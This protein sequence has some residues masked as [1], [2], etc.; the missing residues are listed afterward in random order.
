MET[1]QFC[2]ENQIILYSFLPNCTHIMQM[3]D[4][5]VFKSLK[6][7]YKKTVKEWQ[8]Q[9]ENLD[10]SL[11]K[12]TFC[13]LIAHVLQ[14]KNLDKCIRNGFR[15]TGIFP[16]DPDAVDY[17]KCV[18]NNIE[19]LNASL[20]PEKPSIDDIKTT[21]NVIKY[22]RNSLICH[23]INVDLLLEVLEKDKDYSAPNS[24][25]SSEVV[26]VS[27]AD[28]CSKLMDDGN[29][30]H[31]EFLFVS[32]ENIDPDL[33]YDCEMSS[34]N[35]PMN[36]SSN[37]S[38]STYSTN[39]SVRAE[40]NMYIVNITTNSIVE[41][42]SETSNDSTNDSDGAQSN[43]V[44]ATPSSV[45][46]DVCES[47]SCSDLT[48]DSDRTESN[49]DIV[50]VTTNS[51]P[52]ILVA[53][54][55]PK[56]PTPSVDNPIGQSFKKHLFY[57]KPICSGKKRKE[58]VKTPMAISAPEWREMKQRIEDEKR[59]KAEAIQRRKRD[60]IEKA[61]QKATA[62]EERKKERIE[63]AKAKAELTLNRLKH[64]MDNLKQKKTD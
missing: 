15:S 47:S 31:I 33:G 58:K 57:P 43:I 25:V 56:F 44:D 30:D 61:K 32:D 62:T 11:T 5:S 53:T 49:T 9:S 1:S 16:F 42:Y 28:H 12:V 19:K 38:T 3:A 36:D 2:H 39:D 10:C 21:S 14:K 52:E 29:N 4:V 40:S 41:Y 24:I 59:E 13:P 60:R 17:T 18:Q 23:E 34:S 48:N 54:Q 22:M 7:D 20:L 27:E 46:D 8:N 26:S 6:S 35:D 37:D 64:K 45:P 51:V 55:S 63:K 50:N